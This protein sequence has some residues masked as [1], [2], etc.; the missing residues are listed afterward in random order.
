[1]GKPVPK[2]GDSRSGPGARK[3]GDKNK[4][5]KTVAKVDGG[6]VP[7]W[8]DA[9]LKHIDPDLA[10]IY[11]TLPTDPSEAVTYMQKALICKGILLDQMYLEGEI[12]HERLITS[13]SDLFMK[14]A[15]L[16]RIQRDAMGTSDFDAVE[17]SFLDSGEHS[18]EYD[19]DGRVM[20]RL[21]DTED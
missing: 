13:Q 17:G 2:R 18:V 12:G 21:V 10:A 14:A 7:E 4:T 5:R 9:C 20:L 6:D 15:Q 11:R 1:M 8:V 16:W 3:P 19:E